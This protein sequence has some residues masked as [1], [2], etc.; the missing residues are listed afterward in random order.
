MPLSKH[1]KG[2]GEKVMK[3]MKKE[4]GKNAEAIFYATENKMKKGKGKT[5][6]SAKP[7]GGS[8]P[9]EG[10]SMP[11]QLGE[12]DRW[13]NDSRKMGSMHGKGK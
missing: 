7:K 8:N 6:K 11:F 10:N 1:Y 2:K 3:A 5:P 4:Y 12:G 13:F 9:M